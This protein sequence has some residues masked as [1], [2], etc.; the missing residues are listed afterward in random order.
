MLHSA[1]FHPRTQDLADSVKTASTNQQSALF[2][3]KP[4][5]HT[6]YQETRDGKPDSLY[7]LSWH[8]IIRLR[9]GCKQATQII[10]ETRDGMILRYRYYNPEYQPI[11][12]CFFFYY[13]TSNWDC[14]QKKG[15][16][17]TL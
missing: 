9:L 8:I 16:N 10:T 4:H 15:I 6:C 17:I 7:R 13:Y 1:T 5:L 2:L 3:A 11:Q 14:G 12:Y